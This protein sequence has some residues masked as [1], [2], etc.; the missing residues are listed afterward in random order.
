MIR[1]LSA[2]ALLMSL[3][4][5]A[6]CGGAQSALDPAGRDAEWMAK[7][8]V[9][10]TAAFVVIWVGVVAL[11]VYAP[12]ARPAETDRAANTLITG[13]GVALPVVVLSVL[14]LFGFSDLPRMLAPA[15]EGNL[16][17]EVAGSQWWWRVRYHPRD[18]EAIELANELH[19][20]LGRRLNT[21][22]IS[23]DVV[24]S[25]WIP[26]IAGKMDMIPGRVNRLALEAT[27]VGRFRGACAEYCGTSHARMNMVVVVSDRQTF[28]GW[29]ANQAQPA[30]APSDPLAQRGR[31]AFFERGCM[32]CHTIRGT[33]AAGMSGP[34]LTHVGGRQTLA[35]G[36]LATNPD[37][38]RRWIAGTEL[39]KP[40]V[41][42]PAF[43]N[44]PDEDLAA[45]GAYLVH[46]Q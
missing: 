5:I 44:L 46:L 18:R 9:W 3:V 32:T 1:D 34:D 39:L 17:I 25:F 16:T 6:G 42:M 19:L 12:R 30:A 36:L 24:H 26:A 7:L 13:G 20:P 28:D 40:G 11:A 43:A 8:F 41:H 33:G 15:P 37:A 29:L 10:L 21:R 23:A 45:L 22:L 4:V 35:A 2:A 14:L 38:F 27:R 31:N